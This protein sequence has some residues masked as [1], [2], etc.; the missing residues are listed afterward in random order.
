MVVPTFVRQALADDPIT[1]FGDGRQQRCFCHVTDVV[2]AL[3]DLVEREER[4]YGEVF[5]V[6]S[7]EEV[8]I[9]ELAERVLDADGSRLGDRD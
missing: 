4:V 8:T 9:R 2:Q 6:G 7:T 1:V 3:A 5:N